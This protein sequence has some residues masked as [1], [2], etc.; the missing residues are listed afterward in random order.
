MIAMLCHQTYVFYPEVH[1]I[2]VFPNEVLLL[3]FNEHFATTGFCVFPEDPT[4]KK[5]YTCTLEQLQDARDKVRAA[6]KD[7]GMFAFVDEA[8]L[9][10]VEKQLQLQPIP[11][12]ANES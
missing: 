10:L 6:H 12:E 11:R 1:I 5:F 2:V 4:N 7:G 3:H 9:C 8:D